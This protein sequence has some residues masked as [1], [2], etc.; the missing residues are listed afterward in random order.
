M[1]DLTVLALV[2]AAGLTIHLRL[3]AEARAAR[4][5]QAFADLTA[6]LRPFIAAMDQLAVAVEASAFAMSHL[7]VTATPHVG[8]LEL[9]H[10]PEGCWRSTDDWG[11]P[12]GAPPAD[13]HLVLCTDHHT[14]LQEANA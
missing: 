2:A 3:L 9:V 10:V 13:E 1:A 6:D 7:V 5:R 11:T 8:E 4:I 14:R 12:C